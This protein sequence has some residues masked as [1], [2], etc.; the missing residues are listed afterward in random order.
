MGREVKRVPVDFDHPLSEVWPGYLTPPPRPCPAGSSCVNGYTPDRAWLEHWTHLLLTAAT[1]PTHPWVLEAPLVTQPPTG[2]LVELT[3]VLAGRAPS[4][5]GHDAIDRWRATEAVLRAA[6]L[7]DRWGIC[8]ACDGKAHHP[9]DTEMLDAWEPTEPPTG[10]G[11]QVWETVSEGSP[12]TPVF[13]SAEGLARHL[14]TEGAW[15]HVYDYGVALRFVEAGWAPSGA[16]SAATGF[17]DGVTF[18]GS[19]PA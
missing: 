18:V 8:P 4:D 19:D 5:L 9:D 7:D 15:G 13:D 17:V 14:A 6:G 16:L 1:S 11:W 12:I 3:T 2:A 10:E